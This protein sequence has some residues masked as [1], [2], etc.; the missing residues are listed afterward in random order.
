MRLFL[1]II[2]LNGLKQKKSISGINSFSI[3]LFACFNV[4]INDQ[5]CELVNFVSIAFQDI[6]D[7]HLATCFLG[8][9]QANGHIERQNKIFKK[10]IIKIINKN[11]GCQF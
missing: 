6:N 11:L 5:D 10:A 7:R 8:H 3:R 1:S 9:P 4:Q 2:S